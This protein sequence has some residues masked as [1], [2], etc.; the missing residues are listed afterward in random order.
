MHAFGARELRARLRAGMDA[1]SNPEIFDQIRRGERIVSAATFVGD[2]DDLDLWRRKR[3][4]W[5][6]DVINCLRD[7][8][9]AETLHGFERAVRQPPV[10]GDLHEDLPVE[11]EYLREALD[12]VRSVVGTSDVP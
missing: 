1:K 10:V 3:A 2:R 6:G 4:S 11:V 8:V 9:D 12:L 7:R 5:A